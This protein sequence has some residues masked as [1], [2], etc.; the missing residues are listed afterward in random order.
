[1]VAAK[2]IEMVEVVT[3]DIER[4]TH[5]WPAGVRL[6]LVQ[7]MTTGERPAPWEGSPARP[8]GFVLDPLADELID[9]L[10]PGAGEALLIASVMID[11]TPDLLQEFLDPELSAAGLV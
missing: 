11:L 9:Q 1:L 10:P 2:D 4:V 6:A 3:R 5:G 8:T 7:A